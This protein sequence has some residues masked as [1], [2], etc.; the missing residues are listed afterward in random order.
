MSDISNGLD[1]CCIYTSKLRHIA[2]TAK[3]K[4]ANNGCASLV[5]NVRHRYLGAGSTV[6]LHASTRWGAII[7][8]FYIISMLH[9]NLGVCIMTIG[10]PSLVMLKT[11]DNLHLEIDLLQGR[12]TMVTWAFMFVHSVALA[13]LNALWPSPL[14]EVGSPSNIG[15]GTIFVGQP[16]TAKLPICIKF[17]LFIIWLRAR[18]VLCGSCTRDTNGPGCT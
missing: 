11:R 5:M 4:A 12:D 15:S 3:Y 9:R 2:F 16:R 7:S 1:S 6:L 17:V 10:I 13:Y 8:L 18:E 14:V